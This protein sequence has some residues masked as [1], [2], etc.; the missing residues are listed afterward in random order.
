MDLRYDGQ[1]LEIDLTFVPADYDEQVDLNLDLSSFGGALEG[2]SSLV[3]VESGGELDV[4]IDLTADVHLGISF[5]EPQS[6]RFYVRDTSRLMFTSEVRGE[7][8]SFSA[9]VGPVEVAIKDGRVILDQ[10]GD[11][12][13]GDPAVDDAPASVTVSLKPDTN[14]YTIDLVNP[15][16]TELGLASLEPIAVVAAADIVLPLC[17]PETTPLLPNLEIRIPDL[18]D[19]GTAQ[20]TA[21]DLS[22][23]LDGFSLGSDLSAILDGLDLLLGLIQDGLDGEVL[24]INL[25]LVGP[26]LG[27]AADFIG[28]FRGFALGPAAAGGPGLEFGSPEAVREPGTGWFW[29]SRQSSAGQ[30]R[31]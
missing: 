15:A 6:P 26:H 12:A 27:D 16:N 21:P 8:L 25:P 5:E 4:A 22:A 10:N 11:L 31:F 28:E 3:G 13:T 7:D 2:M 18:F 17:Y 23:I 20:V 24:G 14:G 1:V 29:N 19:L 9:W 30:R